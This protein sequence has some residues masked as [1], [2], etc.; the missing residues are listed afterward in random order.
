MLLPPPENELSIH[1]RQKTREKCH[2]HQGQVDLAEVCGSKCPQ[3]AAKG[4]ARLGMRTVSYR[5]YDCKLREL[6]FMLWRL[7]RNHR[8]YS[9]G[10]IVIYMRSANRCACENNTDM[11]TTTDEKDA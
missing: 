2:N 3:Q 1:C 5:R 8:I 6:R 11:T 9:E 7:M 4:W 10:P